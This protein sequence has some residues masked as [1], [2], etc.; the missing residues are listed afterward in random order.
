MVSGSSGGRVPELDGIRGIAIG[1][2]LVFHYFLLQ[3]QVTPG[4]AAAYALATGR[5]AWSGVD[6]F[7]VLSGFLIGGILL[8]ARDSSNYFQVFYTRRFFRIVPIYGVLLFF[9]FLM[10]LA[11]TGS[12]AFL[13]QGLLHGPE[14]PWLP[15]PVFLQNFW[16]AARSSFGDRNLG[17]T[18]SLAIEEQFYL[19]LPLVIRICSPRTL[20]K[21]LIAGVLSAPVLRILLHFMLPSYPF[22]GTVLMPCRA[23]TLLIGVLCAFALRTPLWRARLEKHPRVLFWLLIVLCAG[24]A[25]LTL[26]PGILPSICAP[27]GLTWLAAFYASCLLYALLCR[28]SWLSRCLRWKWIGWLGSIAY[29]VYLFHEPVRRAFLGRFRT[30]D[31]PIRSWWEFVLTVVA[32]AAT[33]VLCHVSWLYFEKPLIRMGHRSN[34]RFGE[35]ARGKVVTLPR[36]AREATHA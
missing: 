8:D 32:L 9:S 14:V 3:F 7:F 28:G 1:M 19:T 29:G 18:W 36:K 17:V 2:I 33:F 10:A 34:F 5:L 6:L 21:V 4:T 27:L 16:M 35:S 13:T 12:L 30:G 24:C 20:T 26:K 25:V 31:L 11:S 22:Y 23:D 15:Y